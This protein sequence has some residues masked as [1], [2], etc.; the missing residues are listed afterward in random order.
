MNDRNSPKC[1]RAVANGHAHRRAGEAG[2]PISV[3]A[4]LAERLDVLT[5]ECAVL[6]IPADSWAQGTSISCRSR[7]SPITRSAHAAGFGG[8]R[9]AVGRM[10]SD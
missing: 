1:S 8:Q 5:T 2:Q 3:F 9:A 7:W 6:Q 4:A 10:Q